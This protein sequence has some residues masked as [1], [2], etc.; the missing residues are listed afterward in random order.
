MAPDVCF[1]C[2]YLRMYVTYAKILAHI[3]DYLWQFY[4]N[5]QTLVQG[6]KAGCCF[7]LDQRA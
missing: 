7:C 5:Y 1:L 4:G 6:P 2:W 3:H